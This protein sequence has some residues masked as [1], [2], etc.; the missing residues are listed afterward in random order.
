MSDF[1]ERLRAADP[2]ASSDYVHSDVDAMISRIMARAPR[3]RQHVL[4]SFQLRM[5][6][7]VALAAALTIG[8][9]AALEG[10]APSLAVFALAAPS[11]NHAALGAK[12]PTASGFGPAN[13]PASGMMRI[14]E[15][16]N[17][18]AGS[19]L[20]ANAGP[21]AAYQLQLPANA[22]A[23]AARI[24]TIFGVSGAP[25]ET[26]NDVHDL[27]VTD[28]SGSEVQ[29]QT[30]NAVP[31]WSYLVATPHETSTTTSDGTTVAMPSRSTVESDVQRYLGQLGY[32]YQ[33]SDPQFSSSNT[34]TSS[35]GQA[36]VTTNE[37]SVS[38]GVTVGGVPT[39][40]SFQFAVDQNNNVVS[41]NGP[42]FSASPTVNYPL[43]SPAAGV[44]VLEAQQQSYFAS[45]GSSVQSGASGSPSSSGSTP[46]GPPIIDVTLDHA[47]ITYQTYRLTD[48]S[49]WMLPI[50]N[51]TG[52]VNN[53]DGSSYTATWT[54]IAVDPAY[55]HLA[56]SSPGGIDPGG[57]ILY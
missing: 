14:Y 35:P 46:A 22:S 54:T 3:E 26:N 9:I 24:A 34:V 23:E 49:V 29:Y 19:D 7:S 4:R 28:T 27:T 50:Y 52:L 47:T 32:G 18:T 33:L 12:T 1:E 40:Q 38:Y 10:A 39:D 25:V 37:E 42:A 31:Q 45:N 13:Q 30:Y 44:A 5:A 57:P 21:G 48:G 15:E 51:Y 16:F 55:I 2:A 36:A 53:S 41:A 11:H 43:Q 56:T 8:G 20:S 6:G 17:F